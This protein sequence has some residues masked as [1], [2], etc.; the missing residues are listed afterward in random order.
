MYDTRHHLVRKLPR[1]YFADSQNH[2]AAPE[3]LGPT[4]GTGVATRREAVGGS[5]AAS[6]PVRSG[7]CAGSVVGLTAGVGP[8]SAPAC[9]TTSD[10]S[11]LARLR[12]I[13]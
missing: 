13:F 9:L 7:D 6:L 5:G 11:R 4:R 8:S 2:F 1:N 3:N 12:T 10:R